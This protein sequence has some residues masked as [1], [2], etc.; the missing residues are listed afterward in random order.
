MTLRCK[1]A[2]SRT[3]CTLT[4]GLRYALALSLILTAAVSADSLR[5]SLARVIETAAEYRAALARVLPFRERELARATDDLTRRRELA[6]QGIIARRDVDDAERAVTHART[7]LEE[8]QRDIARTEATMLE[9]ETRQRLAQ[10]PPTRGGAQDELLS[11]GT[12]AWA[13]DDA[14]TIERFFSERFGRPLPISAFGQTSVHDRLGFDH[15][16]ALDVALHPDSVEGRALLQYL[17]TR[18]VPFMAF[19]GALPGASTGAHVH[20]GDP[21]PRR[22]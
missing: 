2:P 8:L 10:A 19:R 13:L 1:P 20:I 3:F 14:T 21:S 5:E 16:N 7:M 17:R 22:G 12:H 11:E 18:G 4:L 6:A 9:A 15:R